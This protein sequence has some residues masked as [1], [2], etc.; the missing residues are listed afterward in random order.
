MPFTAQELQDIRRYVDEGGR[1]MIILGEGGEHKFNTNINAMLEQIG[2]SVNN[3]CVI[4]KTYF[5]YLHPKE[6]FI[7]NGILNTELVRYANNLI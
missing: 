7:G 1:A 3:D 2:I 4:R 6:A 5:K